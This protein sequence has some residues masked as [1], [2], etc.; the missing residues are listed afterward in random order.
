MQADSGTKNPVVSFFSIPETP[1]FVLII[2]TK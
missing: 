2:E 1:V